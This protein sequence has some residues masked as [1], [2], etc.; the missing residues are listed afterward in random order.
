MQSTLYITPEDVTLNDIKEI[1]ENFGYKCFVHDMDTSHLELGTTETW[2][3]I[4][5]DLERDDTSCWRWYSPRKQLDPI[6]NEYIP[7]LEALGIKPRT[8]FYSDFSYHS[9][10]EVMHLSKHIM[11]LYGGCLNT[12]DGF[13]KLFTVDDV[14]EI[15]NL[16]KN[17]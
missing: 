17:K 16:Y 5:F 6:E 13:G 8:L 4:Y 14:L 7:L 3:F 1:A 10:V 15:I 12:E 9:V 2:L 11:T